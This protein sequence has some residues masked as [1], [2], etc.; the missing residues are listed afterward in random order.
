MCV[1]HTKPPNPED[2]FDVTCVNTLFAQDWSDILSRD[3]VT[4]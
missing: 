3:L 2:D 4:N 1:Q